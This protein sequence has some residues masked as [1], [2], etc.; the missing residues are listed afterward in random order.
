MIIQNLA[1]RTILLG[2][3]LKTVQN[4]VVS[5]IEIEDEQVKGV[6]ETCF[7]LVGRAN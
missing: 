6:L 3:S 7:D 1:G 5:K 4:G 2:N